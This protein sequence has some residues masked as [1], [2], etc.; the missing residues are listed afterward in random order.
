MPPDTDAGLLSL[1]IPVYNE[2]DSLK[3]LFAEIAEVATGLDVRVEVLFV[4]DGS[5]DA[6]WETIRELA[7]SDDRVRGLRFRRTTA[8]SRR[9]ARRCCAN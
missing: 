7:A 2:K 3:A 4:D 5:T 8:A 1:V 6:S 9:T